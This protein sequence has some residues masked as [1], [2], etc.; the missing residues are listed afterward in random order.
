M[1]RRAGCQFGKDVRW[2]SLFK[3]ANVRREHY[4]GTQKLSSRR[5]ISDTAQAQ[6]F[7]P[8]L[9]LRSFKVLVRPIWDVLETIT[10]S[11]RN[12]GV[13]QVKQGVMPAAEGPAQAKYR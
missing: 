5:S 3:S 2:Q 12:S 8:T 1:V 4:G 9:L 11:R 10:A 6:V 7:R 13:V